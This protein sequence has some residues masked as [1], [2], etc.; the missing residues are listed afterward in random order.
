MR[1]FNKL[2]ADV[3]TQIKRT[4]KSFDEVNVIFEYGEF[5]VST[6]I[7][8]KC[9]YADDHEYIGCY[10]AKDLFTA[11]ERM[12][13]YVEAFHEF[14]IEYKGKRDYEMLHSMTWEDKVTFDTD[15]NII[16]AGAT[17]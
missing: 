4:L 10:R 8:V 3:Q 16:K 11:D 7:A 13:N 15:H 17:A 14:P 6:G 5:H 2:P 9:H 12:L 1:D